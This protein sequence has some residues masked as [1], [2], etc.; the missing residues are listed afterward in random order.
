[1][2]AASTASKTAPPLIKHRGYEYLNNLETIFH[3]PW[4]L[5]ANLDEIREQDCL[6]KTLV[7]QQKQAH[8]C[9]ECCADRTVFARIA[10]DE[11]GPESLFSYSTIKT[12]S[13]NIDQQL[14]KI[15]A[16]EDLMTKAEKILGSL[17]LPPKSEPDKERVEPPTSP[18]K[19]VKIEPKTKK[20][21]KEAEPAQEK[22]KIS[23]P[24]PVTAPKIQ[25][26]IPQFENDEIVDFVIKNEQ[27]PDV[28]LEA[29]SEATDNELQPDNTADDFSS[30][31]SE[32]SHN[33]YCFCERG[34]HGNMIACDGADCK[35]EWFHF[36]CVGIKTAPK[37]KWF[38]KE[39]AKYQSGKKNGTSA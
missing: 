14:K 4:G 39:C 23:L 22:A 34:S 5:Q 12:L 7:K 18:K 26:I 8:A 13:S 2:R 15:S 11:F 30:T 35:I 29:T 17:D 31:N 16:M 37:G 33:K 20:L 25:E 28:N 19:N 32:S 1:M 6:F 21:K 10:N 38:C 36:A 9:K 24:A 3:L 27:L